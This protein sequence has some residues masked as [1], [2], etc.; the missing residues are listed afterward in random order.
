MNFKELSQKFPEI[1]ESWNKGLDPKFPKGES[2]NDV[3]LR[4]KNL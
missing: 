2:L 3:F 4:L 1:I